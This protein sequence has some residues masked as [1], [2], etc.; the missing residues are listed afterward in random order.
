MQKALLALLGGCALALPHAALANVQ[1]YGLVDTSIR[2]STNENAAGDNKIQMSDGA[3]TGSR[4]GLRGTEDLGSNLKAWYI[5]ESGF[6]PDAGTSLQGGR[7]FGR[8]AVVGLDGEF[9]KLAL[10]RQYALL[11]EMVSSYD[12]MGI[13][14]LAIVGYQANYTGLRY[15]NTIKYIKSFGGLQLAAAYTFGETPGSL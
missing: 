10:G 9:G 13:A 14:N 7:L 5:L 4:W 15:D 3:L 6:A 8:M 11:H 12:A 2:F 1:L